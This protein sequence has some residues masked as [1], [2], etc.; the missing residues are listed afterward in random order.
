[1]PTAYITQTETF[2]LCSTCMLP[3]H[4]STKSTYR[5]LYILFLYTHTHTHSAPQVL[6][7]AIGRG[8]GVAAEKLI[9]NSVGQ[10]FWV[11]LENIHLA[12][13]WMGGLCSLVQVGGWM[14]AQVYLYAWA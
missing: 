4:V 12:G 14:A 8:Q 1:M 2:D 9:R 13:D 5:Y 3:A 11:V 7:L 10:G 6:H